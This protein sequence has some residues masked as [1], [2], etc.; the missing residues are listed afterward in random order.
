MPSKSFLVRFFVTAIV[1]LIALIV[2]AA[3]AALR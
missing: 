3:V 2:L 1:V